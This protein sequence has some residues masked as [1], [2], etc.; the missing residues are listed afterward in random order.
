MSLVIAPFPQVMNSPICIGS[1]ELWG[2]QREGSNGLFITNSLSWPYL[3]I[4]PSI[5][6]TIKLLSPP[7]AHASQGISR[8]SVDPGV[9]HCSSN[10]S[11][12]NL[13]VVMKMQ[14]QSNLWGL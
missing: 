12:H 2:G 10:L 5:F 14:M 7:P 9:A 4:L 6:T 11:L 8:E 3:P 1:R 13:Q